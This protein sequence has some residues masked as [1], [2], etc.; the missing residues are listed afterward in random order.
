[1]QF[2]VEF[3]K[4]G[5]ETIIGMK[6]FMELQQKIDFPLSQNIFGPQQNI[7]DLRTCLYN[8]YSFYPQVTFLPPTSEKVKK[9]KNQRKLIFFS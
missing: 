4:S 5:G 9:K 7:F 1:M 2:E 6:R 3:Y 8:L